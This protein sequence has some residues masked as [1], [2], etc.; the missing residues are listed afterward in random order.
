MSKSSMSRRDLLKA[1]GSLPLSIPMA[2]L[3]QVLLD[4]AVQKAHAAVTGKRYV[5]IGTPGGP[6]RWMFDHLLTPYDTTAYLPNGG[7][8]TVGV[9]SGTGKYTSLKYSVSPVTVNGQTLN[10]P[11]LWKS[12][13][14]TPTGT[15]PLSSL[16]ANMMV[17]RG[18]NVGIDGHSAAEQLGFQPAGATYTVMGLV[19][20][21]STGCPMKA[22]R[23]GFSN[24][25]FNSATGVTPTVSSGSGATKITRLLDPFTS[26]ASTAFKTPKDKVRA[27]LDAAVAALDAFAESQHP[28]A[29]YLKN[30]RADA[31]AMMARAASEIKPKWDAIFAKYVGL[32]Q[33]GLQVQVAGLTDKPV[34]DTRPPISTATESIRYQFDNQTGLENHMTPVDIRASV[35]ATTDVSAMA[36]SFALAELAITLGLS[37][38]VAVAIGHLEKLTVNGVTSAKFTSDQHFSGALVS[39][40]FNT[41]LWAAMG[42]CL[43]ELVSVLKAANLFD[44]TVI[45]VGSE[46]NRTPSHD[47]GGTGHG[48][49]A[50]SA[51]ILSGMV[52][53]PMV[54]GN[55]L[56]RDPSGRVGQQGTWGVGAPSINGRT[57]D[58]A[59]LANALALMLGVPQIVKRSSDNDIIAL[60]AGQVISKIGLGR[61]V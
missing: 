27:Q 51:T 3:V 16:L 61:Q 44:Q 23:S 30:S 29:I 21:A 47:L 28:G 56:M 31:D 43:V 34:G 26:T 49:Q 53:S 17:I 19:A 8:G 15:A 12:M 7:V 4:G 37:N 38:S 33:Q 42:T 60:S 11:P 20:D 18:I 14:P 10:V 59:D 57:L 25:K 41:K 50:S 48:W 52:K 58:P 13:V 40:Y 24:F 45:H 1:L 54:I 55:I 35:S 22:L 36:E 46:F 5:Y 39:T 9:D 2:S 6:P 32:V